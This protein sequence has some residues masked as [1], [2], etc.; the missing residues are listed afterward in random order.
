MYFCDTTYLESSQEFVLEFPEDIKGNSCDVRITSSDVGSTDVEEILRN[1][2]NVKKSNFPLTVDVPF[3][4]YGAPVR[5]TVY[6]NGKVYQ[7]I[8]LYE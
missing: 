1:E 7:E 5:V 4:Y 8:V 6:I 2:K 3:S